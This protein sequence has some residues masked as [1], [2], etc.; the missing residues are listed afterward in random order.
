MNL[1][2]VFEWLRTLQWGHFLIN[3]QEWNKL[4]L[5]EMACYTS[6][7]ECGEIRIEYEFNWLMTWYFSDFT[8][9]LPIRLKFYIYHSFECVTSLQGFSRI[10]NAN[11]LA[12]VGTF[13]FPFL[14]T[15][16]R[17]FIGACTC[18]QIVKKNCSAHSHTWNEKKKTKKCQT[19]VIVGVWRNRGN[20]EITLCAIWHCTGYSQRCVLHNGSRESV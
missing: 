4:F 2:I 6:S 5:R 10:Q 13:Y 1:T 20:C 19:S 7:N 16:A 17:E 3:R 8:R 11:L 14:R 12:F 15:I 9:E 18:V